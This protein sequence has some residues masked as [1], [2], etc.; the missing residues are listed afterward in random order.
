MNKIIKTIREKT[1]NSDDIIVRNIKISTQDIYIIFSEVLCDGRNINDFIV[2]NISKLVLTNNTTNL[3]SLIFN[4]ISGT[5]LKETKNIYEAIDYIFKGFSLILV[6]NKFI[7]VEMRASIDRGINS[8]ES[9]VSIIGPKDSFN[10]NFNTNLGLIRRRIRT[11]ELYLKTLF[12]GKNSNTKVGICY[13][14]NIARDELV[15]NVVT[16]LE[17]INIDG[18]IDSGYIREKLIKKDSVFPVINITERPDNVSQ[19]L[20]EGKIIIIVDNSPYV[21]IIPTFFIDF[22]HTPDDYYQKPINTSFIRIIRLIGFFIAIFLPAYYIS[23]TT[24]NTSSIPISLLTNFTSQRLTVPF[25]AFIEALIMI[26]CFEILRESDARIPSKMGTSVSIL[27][28]LVIG[29]SAVSAGLVSPIMIIVIAIS[30][31]SGLIFTSNALTSAIR[32][33][34]I[35]LLI[36]STFFGIYGIFIGLI[37]LI[38]KLCSITSFGFPYM[39]PLSPIIK[40]ELKDTIIRTKKKNKNNRNP[41]LAPQNITRE[42]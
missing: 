25:P 28:G 22:L 10:E 37:F 35:F 33:Y 20:L 27:G 18:I 32:Y 42:K 16:K 36:L 7:I 8:A 39:A 15:N 1:G 34:R 21:M 3:Y 14:N 11:N 24:H 9:E 41:L 31:I 13:M 30:A 5:N 4:T 26:I 12:I 23:V 38:T 40:S 17:K 29:E 6:E 19:A 2:R